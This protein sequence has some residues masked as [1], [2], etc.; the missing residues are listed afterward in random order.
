MTQRGEDAPA[1]RAARAGGAE[2]PVAL[3]AETEAWAAR[4]ACPRITAAGSPAFG[5]ATEQPGGGWV[6][7]PHH[8]GPQ[9]QGVRD[10]LGA[11]FRLAAAAAHA[12]GDAAARQAHE[13]A[14]RRLERE[15]LDE[16][17]VCGVRHRVVRAELFIRCGPDGPEPPRVTDPGAVLVDRSGRWPDPWAGFVLD[18]LRPTGMAEGVLRVEL[19]GYA[20]GP[21]W[22]TAEVRADARVAARTH[23]GG[24]LLPVGF[25]VA[26]QRRPDAPW[27]P[28]L[29]GPMGSPQA[30]RESLALGLR[31]TEPAARGL[32]AGQRAALAAAA[33]RLEAERLDEI[34]VGGRRLRIVRMEQLVRF[35]PDGPEGP[36]PSDRDDE[37]PVL[38][39]QGPLPT[40]RADP[41]EGGDDGAE[42]DAGP[43]GA[44][45]PP[46]ADGGREPAQEERERR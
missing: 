44:R 13:T 45:R 26:E 6:L 19:L 25:M 16:L 35:G 43:V 32:D 24:V 14:A 31:V 9:P 2:A 17:T 10:A 12:A 15:V 38:A 41:G 34:R 4:Q 11:A 3:L 5:T 23:P 1:G 33:D 30:A 28:F 39:Q 8:G 42:H 27:T 36:R 18:P 21:A 29:P 22:T 40:Q 20:P 46:V 37:L 7:G